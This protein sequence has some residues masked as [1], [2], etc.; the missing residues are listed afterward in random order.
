MSHCCFTAGLREDEP[1]TRLNNLDYAPLAEAMARVVGPGGR[2][3]CAELGGA[4][5]GD[6]AWYGGLQGLHS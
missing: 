5:R 4:P 1:G 6:H 2:G 3:L